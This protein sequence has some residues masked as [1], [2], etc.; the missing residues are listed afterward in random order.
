[1]S[2]P[3]KPPLQPPL[4]ALETATDICSVALITTDGQVREYRTQGRGV[5]SSY[6]FMY[7]EDLLRKANLRV[8]DLNGVILSAGPGSYTGLRV[9][10]SAVKGLLHGTEVRLFAVS[11][12]GAIALGAALM[13]AS[14]TASQ[15]AL[16]ARSASGSQATLSAGAS[17]GSLTGQAPGQPVESIHPKTGP[18]AGQCREYA[19]RAHWPVAVAMQVDAV[20][21]ARRQHVYHQP[22][23]VA[24]EGLQALRPVQVLA[25]NEVLDRWRDGAVLAGTG[26]ERLH[27]L[28]KKQDIVSVKKNCASLDANYEVISAAHVL[29]FLQV[30]A[31]GGAAAG[32]DPVE[33]RRAGKGAAEVGAAEER[34][35][36]ETSEGNDYADGSLL[37]EVHTAEFEPD[38]YAE[39]S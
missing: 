25:L 31:D 22:W 12:L 28:E 7:V 10:S 6:T 37:R 13:S 33:E 14:S 17:A 3:T 1:M 34:R 9:G 35:A 16:S 23:Q 26:L 8:E 21:D 24:P 11:T 18:L 36:E 30:I 39:I 5:H 15:A 2:E 38:Y 29:R 19:A 20:L 32:K 27:S 4:L